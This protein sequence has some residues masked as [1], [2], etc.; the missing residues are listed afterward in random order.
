MLWQELKRIG[1]K[2]SSWNALHPLY[3]DIAVPSV[4]APLTVLF[5]L[6]LMSLYTVIAN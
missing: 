3:A 6:N 4:L 1:Q 2:R 5:F